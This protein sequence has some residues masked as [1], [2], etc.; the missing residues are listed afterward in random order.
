MSEKVLYERLMRYVCANGDVKAVEDLLKQ[1]VNSNAPDKNG[2]TALHYAA[3]SGNDEMVKLLTQISL[4]LR[5]SNYIPITSK[6]NI[7]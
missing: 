2:Y 3:I 1:G 7:K 6:R 5:E 4:S